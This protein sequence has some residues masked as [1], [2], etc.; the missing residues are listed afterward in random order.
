MDVNGVYKPTY[1]W[2]APSCRDSYRYNF[3]EQFQL[4]WEF[5]KWGNFR[6]PFLLYIY[7]YKYNIYPI[8]KIIFLDKNGEGS[9]D[10]ALN[11]ESIIGRGPESQLQLAICKASVAMSPKLGRSHGFSPMKQGSYPVVNIQKVIENCH[12]NSGFTH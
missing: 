1:N 2:E 5:Q 12:R 4:L 10:L 8:T 9:D 11:G 6:K 3:S 7:I